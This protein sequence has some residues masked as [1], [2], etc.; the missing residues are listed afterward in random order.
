MRT[1]TAPLKFVGID[2]AAARS[3]WIVAS[4]TAN[5]STCAMV[6]CSVGAGVIPRC[7]GRSVNHPQR[8]RPTPTSVFGNGL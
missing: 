4:G 3:V 5:P 7:R 8:Y 1:V 6:E 2:V